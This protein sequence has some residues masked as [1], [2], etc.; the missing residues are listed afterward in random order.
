MKGTGILTGAVCTALIM[1]GVATAPAHE[2]AVPGYSP[3]NP[4]AVLSIPDT[5]EAW[6]KLEATPLGSALDRLFSTDG[7]GSPLATWLEQ[8]DEAGAELGASLRPQD[9]FAETISGLDFYALRTDGQVGSVAVLACHDN[10]LPSRVLDHLKQEVRLATGT[11]GGYTADTFEERQ[12]GGRRILELPAFSLYLAADG[13]TLV[14]ATEREGLESASAD[15]GRAT[16]NSEFFRRHNSGL[17]GEPADIW[18]FGEPG[19]VLPILLRG[20]INPEI[21]AAGPGEQPSTI[22]RITILSDALKAT[23]Y[24]PYQDMET[25][26]QRLSRAAPPAGPLAALK[27]FPRE[28][29]FHYATN[30]FDGLAFVDQFLESMTAIPGTDV[31]KDQVEAQLAASST[32]L[33]FDVQNDLLANL[34]PEM[35]VLVTSLGE[36]ETLP[37]WAQVEA[38]ITVGLRDEDRFAQ[39]LEIFEESAT[40]PARAGREEVRFIKEASTD[41]GSYRYLDVPMLAEMG[42]VPSYTMHGDDLF[43]VASNRPLMEDV[44]AIGTGTGRDPLTASSSYQRLAR[45]LEA[46]RN[47]QYTVSVPRLLTL[48][49]KSPIL[50]ERA[51]PDSPEGAPLFQVLESLRT[52][53]ATGIYKLDG[54][55]NEYLIQM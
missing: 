22:A 36:D 54:R 26:R 41:H 15:Q 17:E 52:F 11:S 40:T 39:V 14:I 4:R 35:G 48:L 50:G 2:L 47:N 51:D 8:A 38:I 42:L 18:F 6:R 10:G 3:A 25:T 55:K 5:G 19:L 20:T 37:A 7:A 24:Q 30:Y 23:T 29:L 34:G 32:V 12:E 13:N 33:G 1:G 27:T 44:L 28:G 49:R 9:L 21:F 46:N 31:T 45:R 53:T 43:V 16:F